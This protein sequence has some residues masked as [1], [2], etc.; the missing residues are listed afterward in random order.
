MATKREPCPHCGGTGREIEVT[1]LGTPRKGGMC[2][3][4]AGKGYKEVHV[5]DPKTKKG[6]SAK[7]GCFIATA[8]YGSP[9]APEV[10]IFRQF[11]DET[12]L[13]SRVGG[14]FVALYYYVSPPLA[15]LIAKVP[16]LKIMVRSLLLNP[17]L[18]LL[19]VTSRF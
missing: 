1:S 16:V 10:M 7:G 9:L 14:I 2:W 5:P 11:R 19:K 8:T 15:Q 4:C 3:G 6:E 18:R 13:S 17:I 12:L